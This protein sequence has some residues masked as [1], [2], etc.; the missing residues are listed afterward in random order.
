M[1]DPPPQPLSRLSPAPHTASRRSICKRRRFFHPRQHKTAASAADGNSGL[2]LRP[3]VAVVP[4]VL[5]VSV[6]VAAAPEGVTVCGLKLHVVPAGKPEQAKETFELKP[7]TSVTV[8]V[9]VPLCPAWTVRDAGLTETVKFGGMV[10][11][12]LA[13]AL[14]R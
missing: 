8:I 4:D 13:R 6:V 5:T 1:D 10:Y 11:D 7:P 2:E 12:A 3:R 9:V 14:L